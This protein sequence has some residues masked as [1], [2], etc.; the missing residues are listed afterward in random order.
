MGH[1]WYTAL[2]LLRHR[3]SATSDSSESS[4]A[5]IFSFCSSHWISYSLLWA[6]CLCAFLV[7]S[8]SGKKEL[9]LLEHF[10]L[11]PVSVSPSSCCCCGVMSSSLSIGKKN[12]RIT[13]SGV[14]AKPRKID[15]KGRR[16]NRTRDEPTQQRHCRIL[17]IIFNNRQRRIESLRSFSILLLTCSATTPLNACTRS[18]R[19]GIGGASTKKYNSESK[20]KSNTS[21]AVVV[22]CAK[23][24]GSVLILFFKEVS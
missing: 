22:R 7:Q 1:S 17:K 21:E 18:T 11:S 13:R 12:Q 16:I 4:S 20:D 9:D 6:S 2:V 8:G 24:R 15:W 23:K 3:F 19:R 5:S 10:L 14:T